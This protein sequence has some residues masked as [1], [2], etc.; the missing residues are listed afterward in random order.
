MKIK[1]NDLC[2]C[3]S[4]RKYKKCCEV[5]KK[6]LH[7]S[8]ADI[9]VEEKLKNTILSIVKATMIQIEKNPVNNNQEYKF[10]DYVLMLHM[11]I[12]L[13]NLSYLSAVRIKELLLNITNIAYREVTYRN[14]QLN[15]KE[16]FKVKKMISNCIPIEKDLEKL[17]FSFDLIDVNI[18]SLEDNI[19]YVIGD[20]VSGIE[21]ME[22]NGGRILKK[23][24]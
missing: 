14:I 18:E 16:N 22:N 5:L 19:E 20:I 7:E 6:A 10:H 24:V 11:A 2:P 17:D 23:A 9:S 12:A 8:R 15:K 13:W 21:F 3:N 1:R 4:G